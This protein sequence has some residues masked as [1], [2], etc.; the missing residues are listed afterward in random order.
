MSA[1]HKKQLRKEQNA[2]QMTEKQKAAAAEAKKLRI[3]S[4]IFAV[5]I[6]LMVCVVIFTTV[7]NS[8]FVARN[9]TALT[10][11]GVKIS[12][13]EM[14][15]YYVDT[16]NGFV[17]EWGQL[18]SL[19]GL[20]ATTPLNMQVIDE[21]TGETWADHFLEQAIDEARYVYALYNAAR[22]EGRTLS[23]ESITSIESSMS[24]IAAAATAYGYGSTDD[25]IAA[26]YGRGCNEET[27]RHYAEVQYLAGEYSNDYYNNMTLTDEEIAQESEENGADY[28][29][30]SYNYYYLPLSGFYEDL[31]KDENGISSYTPE[32]KA[33]AL[34]KAEAT[35]K[36]IAESVNSIEELDAAIKALEMNKD[37][38]SA[39]S[40]PC[41]D[42][43][44]EY[45][46][47]YLVDW[48]VDPSRKPGDTTYVPGETMT[49]D[50]DGNEVK[51][52]N[53]YYVA[54]FVER[55]EN[56]FPL[57]NVR[58]ILIPHEGGSFDE[59]GNIVYSE[60]EK[61]AT[62]AKAEEILNGFI[63]ANGTEADFEALAN[64]QSKDP[65][66]NTKGG[67]YEDIYPGKMVESF[68]DWCFDES[69]KPGD[70]GIVTS[71][72]GCHI[73]FFSSFSDIIYREYMI[74][75]ALRA[76]KTEEWSSAL[77]EA[78]EMTVKN[79]KHVN[80]GLTLNAGA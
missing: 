31:E 75:S 61:L 26:M 47:D 25:Y 32:Q 63:E 12:N 28:A 60:A 51:T 15:H 69:R 8:G 50:D 3:Y 56:N 21:E 35:A 48:V 64:E 13:A 70:T 55:E 80:T 67:L 29:S 73:M 34:A 33:A 24:S 4:I 43:A 17:N 18:I 7:S 77:T 53:G 39:A 74:D 66:S 1:S 59:Y 44:K 36:E 6:V 71:E 30:F 58:H 20:V 5:A 62:Y 52:V 65:G 78:A 16:V 19:S 49:Y 9:T 72:N 68:N 40:T 41:V 23:E 22:A 76:S 54:Y 10:V 38:E 14:N 45:I 37:I 46:G 79:L 27:F 11:D 42:F 57:V 2:A